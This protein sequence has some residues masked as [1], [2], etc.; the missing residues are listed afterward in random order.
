M[1]L[2][3]DTEAPFAE[4]RESDGLR[5]RMFT[6]LGLSDR[7]FLQV[8]ERVVIENGIKHRV[9]YAYYLVCDGAEVWGYERDPT[10]NVVE[11]RHDANHDRFACEAI[12]FREAAERA[13]STFHDA[14]Y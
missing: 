1:G 3:P 9:S 10:H 2:V 12:S 13:W 4:L 8:N 5:G 6:R 14:E 7:S 11:H